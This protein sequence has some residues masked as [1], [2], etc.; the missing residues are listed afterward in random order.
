MVLSIEF[1]SKLGVHM[2]M[3]MFGF[4]AF[5]SNEFPTP[6]LVGYDGVGV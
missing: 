1:I 4:T 5:K 3:D 6:G 2:V